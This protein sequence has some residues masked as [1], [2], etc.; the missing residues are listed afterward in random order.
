MNKIKIPVKFELGG[1]TI[2]VECED[3][4]V[5]RD[6]CVG[7]ASCRRNK[8]K[9]QT[10]N[11]GITRPQESI[12]ETFFHELVHWV[13]EM[14]CEKELTQN[15]RFVSNFAQ[16]LHQ[17]FKTAEYEKYVDPQWTKEEIE[18]I[19]AKR[20]KAGYEKIKVNKI[21]NMP[22]CDFCD[23]DAINAIPI[24]GTFLCMECVKKEYK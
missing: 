5:D 8:I 11:I 21:D 22:K 6:D 1:K 18:K 19:K 17:A 9:L 10:N 15:E 4:M 2:H 7:Q 13:L 12:E 24:R 14:M 3:K 16:Y 23:N 20:N